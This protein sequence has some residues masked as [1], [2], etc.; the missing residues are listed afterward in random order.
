[1]LLT[2]TFAGTSKA[3]LDVFAGVATE[4]LLNVGRTM[5]FLCD[6]YSKKMSG[7]VNPTLYEA[8]SPH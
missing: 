3:A 1:M 2:L 7:E 5:R 8:R 4:Y 6:K